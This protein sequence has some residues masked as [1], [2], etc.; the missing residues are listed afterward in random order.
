M[1]RSVRC[2]GTP[3]PPAPASTPGS[4]STDCGPWRGS[5]LSE[6][7]GERR[8]DRAPLRLPAAASSAGLQVEAPRPGPA[9]VSRLPGGDR[10]P[11]DHRR[12]R[13]RL[14][15]TARRSGSGHPVPPARG[16]ARFRSLRGHHR[17]GNRDPTGGCI[18]QGATAR[19]LHLHTGTDQHP[20]GRCRATAPTLAGG[21]LSDTVRA[22]GCHRHESRGSAATLPQRRRPIRRDR[23]RPARQVRPGPTPSAAPGGSWPGWRSTR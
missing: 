23:P 8:A 22:A 16:G 19:A 9:P 15:A 6:A 18:R 21:D 13:D 5:G 17:P 12:S 10:C 7:R 1:A 14:G 4:I 2:C 20:G 3:M 11:A